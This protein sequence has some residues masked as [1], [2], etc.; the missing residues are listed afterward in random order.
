MSH[1]VQCSTGAMGESARLP[2][3]APASVDRP[4]VAEIS[5]FER[6][7]HIA[8]TAC[9]AC[10]AKKRKCSGQSPCA[11][12]VSLGIEC[13]LDAESS[14]RRL[15]GTKRRGAEMESKKST[16]KKKVQSLEIELLR[17]R[18]PELSTMRAEACQMAMTRYESSEERARDV[19]GTASTDSV[20][21]TGTDSVSVLKNSSSDRSTED[22]NSIWAVY[23]RVRN[24]APAD[25]FKVVNA[26]CSTSNPTLATQYL[27]QVSLGRL[28]DAHVGLSNLATEYKLI[29]S[30]RLPALCDEPI[31]FAP[32]KPWTTVT[33]SDRLVSHLLSLYFTWDYPC[34]ACLRK[35][36]D[37]FKEMD[38]CIRFLSEARQLWISHP[39]P[40]LTSIQALV[41]MNLT[42]NCLGKDKIGWSCLATAIHMANELKLYEP[43]S[44]VRSAGSVEP[45]WNRAHA[46]TAWGLFEW[47]ALAASVVDDAPRLD[48]PPFYE[49]PYSDAEFLDHSQRWH[50][51]PFS[52]PLYP[53]LVFSTVRARFELSVVINDVTEFILDSHHA[54]ETFMLIHGRLANWFVDLSPTLHPSKNA[55][56]HIFIMHLHF[57][58]SVVALCRPILSGGNPTPSVLSISNKAKLAIREIIFLF[59]QTFGWKSASNFLN[60]A[61]TYGAFNAIP[62]A[63]DGDPRWRQSLETC[64]SGLWYISFSFPVCRYLLRAIQHA[65][66][67]SGFADTDLCPEVTRILRYFSRSVWKK[68]LLE[69]LEAR[70]P[71]FDPQNNLRPVEDLLLSVESLDLNDSND[72]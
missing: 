37:R 34:Y 1:R 40:T 47:Q 3:L 56:P 31:L 18:S 2:V 12:C 49:I 64:I 24:C 38:M 30:P 16:L 20:E 68:S 71:A 55:P 21:K 45:A 4:R 15:G 46:V 22:W 62:F 7:R 51:Y 33:D 25:L 59:K 35:P 44:G 50:P 14:P 41:V 43:L 23:E 17:R 58:L 65:L 8:V 13:Q 67:A 42:Y 54:V 36:W 19:Q 48:H 69:T 29:N 11:A 28:A 27:H 52:G 6:R 53:S 32:A 63:K 26:I 39:Q 66:I 70:Y 72:G 9:S 57:H 60:H 5:P 10:R 61:L